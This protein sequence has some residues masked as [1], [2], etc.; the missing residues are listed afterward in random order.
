MTNSQN[1]FHVVLIGQYRRA[2]STFAHTNTHEIFGPTNLE[3]SRTNEISKVLKDFCDQY[4]NEQIKSYVGTNNI[5][6]LERAGDKIN[7]EFS[8]FCKQQEVQ[9]ENILN[10]CCLHMYVQ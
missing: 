5:P 8:R 4:R 9:K 6:E 3:M 2:Q 1:C 7:N 10:T